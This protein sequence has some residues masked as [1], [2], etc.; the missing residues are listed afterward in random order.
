MSALSGMFIS[1]ALN[2]RFGEQTYSVMFYTSCVFIVISAFLLMFLFDETPIRRGQNDD[3]FTKV[4][5]QSSPH[6]TQ[7]KQPAINDD[8]SNNDSAAN[9]QPLLL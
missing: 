2:D 5:E 6:Q 7:I 1:K 3:D 9:K 4:E 8:S